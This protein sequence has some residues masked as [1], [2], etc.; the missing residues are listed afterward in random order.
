MT[1]KHSFYITVFD[2]DKGGSNGT[3]GEVPFDWRSLPVWDKEIE[4]NLIPE[5]VYE[6]EGEEKGP[7]KP[8]PYISRLTETGLL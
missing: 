5:E 4:E 1:F 6:E 7:G 2:K 8:I 3:D